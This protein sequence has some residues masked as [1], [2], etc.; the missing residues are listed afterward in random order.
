[1]KVAK[2]LWILLCAFPSASAAD[3]RFG[4]WVAHVTGNEREAFT[5]NESGSALGVLCSVESQHCL[6]YLRANTTC[7]EGNKQVALVNTDSG[8]FPID[9]LCSKIRGQSGPEFV[10]LLGS[11]DDMRDV[12]LKHNSIGIAL[13]MTGGQFK[14]V[15]FS[16]IGSNQAIE[17]V[18]H[19]PA[20]SKYRDQM[21]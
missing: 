18:E 14:V 20:R 21:R 12:I 7:S 1:V 10:N 17:A 11:Y 9:M 19:L 16:L 5:N 8:A 2:T 6:A 15:R 13:P 4:D 3:L